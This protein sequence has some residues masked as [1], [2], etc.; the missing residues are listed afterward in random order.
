MQLPNN[1]RD[2][3][4][5][6]LMEPVRPL[7]DR[8]VL[9]LLQERSFNRDHFFE[10]REGICR[11]L[12]DLAEELS[13]TAVLWRNPLR[14][15]TEAVVEALM[16]ATDE[17]ARGLLSLSEGHT[18]HGRQ[19]AAPLRKFSYSPDS[20]TDTQWKN[21]LRNRHKQ[22]RIWERESGDESADINYDEDI[23]PA[24]P[25]LTLK[26]IVDATGLSRGY[27]G[28]IKAGQKVPH[29]RHWS[30]LADLA[31]DKSD[32]IRKRQELEDR[33]RDVN[34]DDDIRPLL[35]KH[36]LRELAEE[37]GLS[38]SYLG[39]IRRGEKEPSLEHWDSFLDLSESNGSR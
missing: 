39:E 38:S 12:P 34:F 22:N 33:F 18:E 23:A 3:L 28:E 13:Q 26:E 21:E 7:I 17:G 4:P 2:S 9:H 10:T 11:I 30:P 15:L 1:R 37:T 16:E 8:Y 6:D 31:T 24:L 35:N 14:E 36:T 25:V 20:W 27:A 29:R 19:I 5:L 32:E